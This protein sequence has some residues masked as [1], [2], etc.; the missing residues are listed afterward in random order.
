MHPR[1]SL[2][3]SDQKPVP[4]DWS[5]NLVVYRTSC[6]F[7]E[8]GSTMRQHHILQKSNEMRQKLCLFLIEAN[9]FNKAVQ[10]SISKPLRN[11]CTHFDVKYWP[12]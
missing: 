3:G 1:K 2:T 6:T 10:A 11:F 12:V 9:I 8:Y 7:V 4:F 5:T